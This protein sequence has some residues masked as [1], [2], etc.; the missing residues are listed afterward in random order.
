MKMISRLLLAVTAMAVAQAQGSPLPLSDSVR[1][2]PV[3][4]MSV[5]AM[6]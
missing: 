1:I 3:A 6:S 2:E 5:F 4:A